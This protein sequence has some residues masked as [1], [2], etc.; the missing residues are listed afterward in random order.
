MGRIAVVPEAE[1]DQ[2][3]SVIQSMV[4]CL[5]VY[6]CIMYK[7]HYNTTVLFEIEVDRVSDCTPGDN[8]LSIGRKWVDYK[9]KILRMIIL[10][11]I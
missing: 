11:T 1:V 10:T 6:L 4:T 3:F 8:L 2:V 9:P 7:D 5:K